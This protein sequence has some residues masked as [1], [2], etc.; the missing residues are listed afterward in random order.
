MKQHFVSF[1][2]KQNHCSVCSTTVPNDS[3]PT[4]NIPTNEL[5][6]DFLQE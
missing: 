3:M 1:H 2:T 6:G 5:I 4:D